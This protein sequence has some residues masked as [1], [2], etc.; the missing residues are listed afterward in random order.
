MKRSMGMADRRFVVSS[1][2]LGDLSVVERLPIADARGF[3]SRLYCR[4]TMSQIGFTDPIAQI[5]QTLTRTKGTVRGL[6]F[7]R[8]PHAEDKMVICLR[9]EVLDVAVDLRVSSPTFLQWHAQNLSA[10]NGLALFIPKGFAHGFQ[11]LTNDCE[12]LYLHTAKYEP[13]AE[14]ALNALDPALGIEWP[15]PLAE[16][17]ARDR[18]HP[19]IDA[20]FGGFES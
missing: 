17:S 11:A 20:D 10:D 15:L 12:L 2:S 19:L 5:N 13:A 18:S 1:T 3:L 7:Q 8:P 4:D 6:H 9:G 16:M 14:G